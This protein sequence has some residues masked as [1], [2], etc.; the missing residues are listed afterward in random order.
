MLIILAGAFAQ[1]V[2]S[3]IGMGF[4]VTSTTILLHLMAQAIENLYPGTHFGIGPC[5]KDN[6]APVPRRDH[7]DDQR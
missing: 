4:G 3:G 6:S 2:N 1:L 5:I 7:G